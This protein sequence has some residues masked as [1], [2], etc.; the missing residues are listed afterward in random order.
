LYDTT[1]WTPMTVP[2]T[3]GGLYDVAGSAWNNVY[4]V[5]LKGTILHY[6]GTS[7]SQTATIPSTTFQDVWVNADGKAFA[8][9]GSED[10][11]TYKIFSYDGNSWKLAYQDSTVY[12]TSTMYQ[13]NVNFFN[14]VWGDGKGNVF[15]AGANGVIVQYDGNIWRKMTT[16]VTQHLFGIAGLSS[17]DIYAAG[18]N[19]VI[20]HY[21]GN[22]WK[23]MDNPKESEWYTFTNIWCASAEE[24]YFIDPNKETLLRYNSTT[25]AWTK[26]SNKD[27]LTRGFFDIWGTSPDNMFAVRSYDYPRIL[28]YYNAGNTGSDS[29]KDGLPDSWELEYFGDLSHNA[30]G[31]EDR[32]GLTNLQEYQKK[33]DPTKADTDRD[34]MPDKWELDHGMNPILDDASDDPDKDGYTNAQ[35]YL[36]GSDPKVIDN[37]SSDDSHFTPVWSGG[38]YFP[39]NLFVVSAMV[40]GAGLNPGDEIGVFDGN[41]CV[42]AAKVIKAISSTD[43]LTVKVS[44]DDGTGNGFTVGHPI[45]FKIWKSAE[46]NDIE[47]ANIKASFTDMNGSNVAPPGFES[48]GTYGVTLEGFTFVTH[49]IPL[50]KG[51]NIVSS[52]VVPNPA[53]MMTLLK[54]F[55]DNS[56]L[57]KIFDET[58]DTIVKFNGTWTNNGIGNFS[59]TEGY[60]INMTADAEWIIKGLITASEIS[61][62]RKVI[63]LT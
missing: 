62:L 8:V 3:A 9:G 55:M 18:N 47:S 14:E 61:V 23:I 58:G 1:T 46:N 24:I 37:P 30:D 41:K 11:K 6:D 20:L 39:M 40:D 17:T 54:P 35:E 51:W 19:E 26:I 45:S 53:D 32:D 10:G 44:Q 22:E 38:T 48:L 25:K 12:Q 50:K 43:Y 27:R 29:D 36:A 63:R 31:D 33:T 7:W 49:S 16:P 57:V 15:V 59:I 13:T 4:A 60:Q 42:G 56:T 28:R 21:D 5:G 34:G 52:Y 2:D